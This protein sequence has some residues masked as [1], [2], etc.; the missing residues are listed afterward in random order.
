MKPRGKRY[1]TITMGQ[2]RARSSGTWTLYVAGR[3]VTVH[4]HRGNS[5]AM[6]AHRMAAALNRTRR[7]TASVDGAAILIAKAGRV[8]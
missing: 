1:W 8:W 6:L 4:I 7:W 2:Q 5:S 3:R